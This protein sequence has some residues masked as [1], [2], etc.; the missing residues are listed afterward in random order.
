[1]MLIGWVFALLSLIPLAFQIQ[2]ERA[3]SQVSQLDN[4]SVQ[5]YE[6]SDWQNIRELAGLEVL[7]NPALSESEF[8]TTVIF[9][10]I[11]NGRLVGKREVWAKIYSPQGKIREGMKIWLTLLPKGR[12]QLEFFFTGTKAEFQQSSIK[13]GF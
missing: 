12:N 9:D 4:A 8:G 2:L 5:F 10:V 3:R 13:L 7:P 6:I 1:M 11:N